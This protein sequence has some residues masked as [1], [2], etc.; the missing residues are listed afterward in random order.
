MSSIQDS[1]LWS[2]VDLQVGMVL[3]ACNGKSPKNMDSRKA[4]SILQTALQDV[5]EN[6]PV[7]IRF[8]DGNQ[9]RES[10]LDEKHMDD[11]YPHTEANCE[12][13]LSEHPLL[14]D[15]GLGT[16]LNDVRFRKLCQELILEPKK[17]KRVF[18]AKRFVSKVIRLL[19]Y[20]L[21]FYCKAYN[22]EQT[23]NEV[24]SHE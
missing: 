20:H 19:L 24:V 9:F 10:W 5:R 8:E 2:E 12:L 14:R 23:V 6:N 22:I 3:V 7:R 16:Y 13:K 4:M 15:T 18:K 1:D 11:L 17:I 21:L